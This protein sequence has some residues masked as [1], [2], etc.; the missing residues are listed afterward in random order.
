MLNYIYKSSNSDYNPNWKI[1]GNIYVKNNDI[2]THTQ[3]NQKYKDIKKAKIN[4]VKSL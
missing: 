3:I 4:M 2:P 1:S